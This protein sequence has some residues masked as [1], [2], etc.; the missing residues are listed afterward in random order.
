MPVHGSRTWTFASASP[1]G[2]SKLVAERLVDA[3]NHVAT[4]SR[5]VYQTPSSGEVRVVGLK[6][7]LVEVLDRLGCLEALKNRLRST[8]ARTSSVQSSTSSRP[9][10]RFAGVASCW[11]RTRTIGT[12]RVHCACRQ[13]K[14]SV[15]SVPA[16]PTRRPKLRR[17]RRRASARERSERSGRRLLLRTAGLV[18]PPVP[19]EAP[20]GAACRRASSTRFKPVRAYAARNQARSAGSLTGASPGAR[21]QIG[22]ESSPCASSVA[23]GSSAQKLSSSAA[24]VN[25]SPALALRPIQAHQ[26]RTGGR[27]RRAPCRS[28]PGIAGPGRTARRAGRC[29]RRP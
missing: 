22:E 19:D 14:R 29:R 4:T 13:E 27:C 9:T 26:P 2:R 10:G 20:R 24:S 5:G 12:D 11:K 15:E 25:A 7:R 23:V 6:E 8:R 28:D 16:A 17:H 3:L 21:V 1:S 18:R